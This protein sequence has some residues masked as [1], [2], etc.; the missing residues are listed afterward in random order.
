MWSRAQRMLRITAVGR[1]KR[2]KRNSARQVWNLNLTNLV[3]LNTQ[4]ERLYE[5]LRSP[6]L[7]NKSYK[8]Y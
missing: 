8:Q 5:T 1:L 4:L 7:K 2:L 6:R 3:Q